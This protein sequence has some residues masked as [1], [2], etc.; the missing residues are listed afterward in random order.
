MAVAE[1]DRAAVVAKHRLHETDTGSAD[2][3]VAL[4]TSRINALADGNYFADNFMAKHG[5]RTNHFCVIAALPDLQPAQAEVDSQAVV[6]DVDAH[7]RP[8]DPPR[9]PVRP[10]RQEDA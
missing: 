3:Q 4:L 7:P 1:A 5:G 8:A 10:R 2:V 9:R 6:V